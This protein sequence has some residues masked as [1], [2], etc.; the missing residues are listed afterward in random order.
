MVLRNVFQRVPVKF[1]KRETLKDIRA[2]IPA[3]ERVVI[4]RGML[5]PLDSSSRLEVQAP[6]DSQV[7]WQESSLAVFASEG[8][9]LELTS[10]GKLDRAPTQLRAHELHLATGGFN[11]KHC[12]ASGTYGTVYKASLP[13]LSQAGLCAIKRV[14]VDCGEDT[15]YEVELLSTCEH[16]NVLPLLGYSLGQ[17]AC[18]LVFPLMVGGTL[19][20]RVL[21]THHGEE[22]LRALGH[23]ASPPPLTWWERV[24]IVRD[25]ARGLEHL[26]RVCRVLHHDIKPSNILLDRRL[27]AR[28]ADFGL[29]A[30]VPPVDDE[31]VHAAKAAA[32]RAAAAASAR[33]PSAASE[34]SLAFRRERLNT[35]AASDSGGGSSSAGRARSSIDLRLEHRLYDDFPSPPAT[36]ATA[37]AAAAEVAHTTPPR[38]ATPMRVSVYPLGGSLGGSAASGGGDAASPAAA[39]RKSRLPT[40]AVEDCTIDLRLQHR[41]YDEPPDVSERRTPPQQTREANAT[42]PAGA[43]ATRSTPARRVSPLILSIG[44]CGSGGVSASIGGNG[45]FDTPSLPLTSAAPAPLAAAATTVV[46]GAPSA[47]APSRAAPV[48][49]RIDSYD[50]VIDP[51]QGS[52]SPPNRTPAAASP[53]AAAAAAAPD[54]GSSPPTPSSSSPPPSSPPPPPSSSS[55]PPPPPPLSPGSG[56]SSFDSMEG[57]APVLRPEHMKGVA[58]PDHMKGIFDEGHTARREANGRPA[59]LAGVSPPPTE[60]RLPRTKPAG[61]SSSHPA[62]PELGAST[63]DDSAPAPPR[64]PGLRGTRAFLDPLYVLPGSAHSGRASPMTDAYAMGLTVLIT[65]TNLPPTTL[66][67]DCRHLLMHPDDQSRWAPPVAPAAD[68][69]AWPPKVACGLARLVAGL[70][71]E[72]L[73]PRRL[74]LAAALKQLEALAATV[75]V[76]DLTTADF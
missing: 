65:L 58:R 32:A 39:A 63:D 26:H 4:N 43:A 56:S 50:F 52:P 33:P 54:L 49:R 17:P 48:I 3:W 18:C 5:A 35:V 23:T 55:P 68:A 10:P 22:R 74:P 9:N 64:R 60:A 21:R 12:I 11:P 6:D 28:L 13:S 20:D 75:G 69:G 66:L 71:W 19:E 62:P 29:A 24:R 45:P 57:I 34:A 36:P 30:A 70:A 53:F 27:N 42:A 1:V 72:P 44:A 41:V 2:I 25:A 16:P 46:S 8:V 14:Q 51:A 47:R 76:D 15:Q 73:A 59:P 7:L 38:R 61:W 40:T 37:T 67:H 31:A